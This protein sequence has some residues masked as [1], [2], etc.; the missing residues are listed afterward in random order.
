M[1]GI[2]GDIEGRLLDR[3]MNASISEGLEAAMEGRMDGQLGASLSERMDGEE[4]D[5]EE[6]DE[7]EDFIAGMVEPGSPDIQTA[8]SIGSEYQRWYQIKALYGF[9]DHEQLAKLLLDFY[10]A[11]IEVI[12]VKQDGQFC[13]LEVMLMRPGLE[14]QMPKPKTVAKRKKRRPKKIRRDF[15]DDDDDFDE[16]L[17]YT[18]ALGEAAEDEEAVDAELKALL[19]IPEEMTDDERKRR[20]KAF[21]ASGGGIKRKKYKMPKSSTCSICNKKLYNHSSL[22]T[23]MKLHSGVKE[24]KCSRCPKEFTYKATLAGH[25]RTHTGEKP[26]SCSVCGKSFSQTSSYKIHLRSHS[27][28]RPYQCPTCGRAF[29]QKG[30]MLVH[31]RI[32]TGEKPFKCTYCAKG[33]ATRRNMQVHLYTHTGEKPYQCNQC[34]KAFNAISTL[35]RHNRIHTGERPYKCT[36]CTQDF[37]DLSSLTRHLDRHTGNRRYKCQSCDEAFYKKNQLITHMKS[38]HPG[39]A[40]P[41]SRSPIVRKNKPEEMQPPKA[42][43]PAAAVYTHRPI[44]HGHGQLVNQ[45]CSNLMSEAEAR[46][47]Q[48]QHRAAQMYVE[49]A[50][51]G[52]SMDLRLQAPEQRQQINPIQA[53]SNHPT[54][55]D[56]YN[57]ATTDSCMAAMMQAGIPAY[58]RLLNPA[59]LPASGMIFPEQVGL[60][61]NSSMLTF[62]HH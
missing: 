49:Q 41:E 45:Q 13:P 21:R 8:L 31:F 11:H 3:R 2:E 20:L 1:D 7:E 46:M 36:L 30:Q 25:M 16:D 56:R 37:S 57:T 51:P 62:L 12:K 39:A 40:L 35:K 47:R 42:E 60:E 6:E 18:P 44:E 10:D 34:D 33:F 9:T 59:A 4:E 26:Y 50:H 54:V 24:W 55:A 52:M 27:G 48:Q 17:E 19:D 61:E 43:M 32:H 15:D 14:V 53:H 29:S 38:R 23:H 22:K 28:E 5:L 58:Q